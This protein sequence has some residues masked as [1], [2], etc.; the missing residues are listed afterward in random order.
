[1]A[2]DSGKHLFLQRLF[3][4]SAFGAI[5]FLNGGLFARVPAERRT[6]AAFS[7]DAY[8]ALIYDVFAQYRFTAAE[9]SSAWSEAA[10]DPEMLGRAFESLMASAE[11]RNTGAFFTPFSTMTLVISSFAPSTGALLR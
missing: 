5:P 6:R 7:D 10:V 8:G 3:V 4:A 11:R 9:E 1:M 2:G